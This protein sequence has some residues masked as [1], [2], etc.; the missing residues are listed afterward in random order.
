[1]VIDSLMT[2]IRSETF[3]LEQAEAVNKVATD[4]VAEWQ[5]LGSIP[6][7]HSTAVMG[8]GKRV[9]QGL[10]GTIDVLAPLEIADTEHLVQ[11]A[12]EL[13]NEEERLKSE[14]PAAT[15]VMDLDD[16]SGSTNNEGIAGNGRENESSDVLAEKVECETPER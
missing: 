1:M 4:R 3:S 12:K 9:L 7:G 10:I 5:S 8:V 15:K 14:F 6:E 13:Q 11:Q 2:L 16:E